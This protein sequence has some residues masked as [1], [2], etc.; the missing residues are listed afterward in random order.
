MTAVIYHTTVLLILSCM[1]SLTGVA[2]QILG[3]KYENQYCS[4]NMEDEFIKDPNS[5]NVIPVG[6]DKTMNVLETQNTQLE[7]NVAEVTDYDEPHHDKPYWMRDIGHTYTFWGCTGLAL[8]GESACECM[9]VRIEHVAGNQMIAINEGE[10]LSESSCNRNCGR[11]YGDRCYV[12]TSE[13]RH[14]G[15]GNIITVRDCK[16]VSEAASSTITS[17][18]FY[19]K[20]CKKCFYLEEAALCDKYAVP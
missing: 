10:Y 6:R 17:G 2:A 3:P 13:E 14:A 8:V 15:G 7:D 4:R 16:H 5:V 20:N 18:R 11:A 12:C 9:I 1:I 19:S